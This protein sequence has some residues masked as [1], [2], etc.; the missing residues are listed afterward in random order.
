MSDQ[1]SPP[2]P[3]AITQWAPRI[4][5]AGAVVGILAILA[6]ALP[7]PAYHSDILGLGTAFG[8]MKY[9]AFGGIIATV[10][11]IIALIMLLTAR[12]RVHYGR[13][14]LGLVLGMLAFGIPYMWLK[15]AESVPPIHDISTDTVNPPQFHAILPLRAKA[16]NSP[17]YGGAAIAALQHKAYPDIHTM[18]FSLYMAQVYAAALQ[19]VQSLGWKLVSNDPATGIIEATDTTFWF[20]FKDDVVIRITPQ[21]S[22]CRLDIRSESRVGKSDIGKNAERI[23]TFRAALYRRLGLQDSA[24][25]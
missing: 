3:P 4:A 15:K 7:G 24:Q 10:L 20:G 6:F 14:L 19:T 5:L 9:G 21:S 12:L 1:P 18:V 2:S 16:P 22:G 23:R 8:L 25:K 13:A 11:S 17:V